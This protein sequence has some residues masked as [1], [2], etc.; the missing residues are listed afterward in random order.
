MLL[1]RQMR[2]ASCEGIASRVVT[3]ASSLVHSPLHERHM[4]LGARLAEFGG[5]EMPIQYA[6]VVEEHL[7]VR[8]AVGV[9]DVSHLGNVDVRGERAKDFV[10]ECLSNDLDRIGPGRAQY[11]LCCDDATGGV[12]DDL[13]VYFTADVDLH[14]VPNAANTAEAVRRLAAAA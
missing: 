1:K 8:N 11:T 12:V 4:A 14:L 3:A 6:G 7:A 5:W 13:I 2:D 10:N 9:F